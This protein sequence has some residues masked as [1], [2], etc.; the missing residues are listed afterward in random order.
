MRTMFT[1]A[2]SIFWNNCFKLHSKVPVSRMFAR[3]EVRSPLT[4]CTCYQRSA[5][6]RCPERHRIVHRKTNAK[7]ESWL[8]KDENPYRD[9]RESHKINRWIMSVSSE[10]GILDKTA[11]MAE[12]EK[13]NSYIICF[14]NLIIGKM[15]KWKSW[16]SRRKNFAR[17][18]PWQV[19]GVLHDVPRWCR[20]QGRHQALTSCDSLPPAL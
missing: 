15:S 17:S 8:H 18:S 10:K 19:H 16:K 9:R 6:D 3:G 4:S 7:G 5:A 20:S 12:S 2:H 1:T 11:E 13:F 14:R